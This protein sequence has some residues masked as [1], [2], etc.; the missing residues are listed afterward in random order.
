MSVYGLQRFNSPLSINKWKKEKTT[1][2]KISDKYLN[3]A[4][5][6][7]KFIA[8]QDDNGAHHSWSPRNNPNEP[9][10]TGDPK[11]SLSVQAYH[12]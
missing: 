1:T 6:Q 10:E 2:I 12:W 8:H 9:G 7:K 4:K 3:V 11:N 5:E